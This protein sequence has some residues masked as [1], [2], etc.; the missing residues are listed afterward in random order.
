MEKKNHPYPPPKKVLV[1][2]VIT[3]TPKEV[4][5]HGP[6]APYSYL[7]FW[8]HLVPNFWVTDFR[9]ELLIQNHILHTVASSCWI[10]RPRAAPLRFIIFIRKIWNQLV[11]P[12]G[13]GNLFDPF[14]MVKTYFQRL[15][16]STVTSNKGINTTTLNH[17]GTG[18]TITITQTKKTA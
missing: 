4:E 15:R 3:F 2:E 1:G 11:V 18:C 13:S 16:W 9:S 6:W 14:E 7:F 8:A 17:L 10:L 5:R 12:I